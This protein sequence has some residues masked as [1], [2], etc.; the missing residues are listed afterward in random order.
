MQQIEKPK[1]LT[2]LVAAELR[3]AIVSGNLPMGSPLSEAKTARELNVSRTPVREAFNRLETESLVHT[4]P[5]RGTFVFSLEPAELAKIC[6]VRVC[7]ETTAMRMA[8]QHDPKG[9]AESLAA[10]AE[11]MIAA[12]AKH[13][14]R[15]YLSEDTVFHQKLF[16]HSGNRFLDDAYQTIAAKMAALR[17]QLG[18]HPEHMTKSFEEH[19]RM[20]AFIGEGG[21]EAAIGVLIDH[22]GRKEGSY[23]IMASE[24]G[25]PLSMPTTAKVG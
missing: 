20:A 22:I 10:C 5:Q 14:D 7:L 11:R 16:D 23:W 19:K 15:A 13:D 2:E 24:D 1:S 8:M 25:A 12:R 6:D 21:T 3:R 4:E 9:L 17:N 18:N